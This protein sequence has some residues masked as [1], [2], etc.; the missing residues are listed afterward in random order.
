MALSTKETVTLHIPPVE[1]S[2]ESI[3]GYVPFEDIDK[4]HKV[5]KIIEEELLK[6]KEAV[7][8]RIATYKQFGI[9]LRPSLKKIDYNS[10]AKAVTEKAT[11]H[12]AE[13]YNNIGCVTSIRKDIAELLERIHGGPVYEKARSLT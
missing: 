5:N 4:A 8:K 12:F 10:V 13:V 9:E 3:L 1:R 6:E 2:I 7:D 11:A